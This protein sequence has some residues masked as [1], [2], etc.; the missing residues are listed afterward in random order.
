[1]HKGKL[2]IYS[3]KIQKNIYPK[4]E[5]VIVIIV[6]NRNIYHLKIRIFHNILQ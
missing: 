1:M 2:T 5:K 3:I 6:E 4:K